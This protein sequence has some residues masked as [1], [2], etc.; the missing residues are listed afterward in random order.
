MGQRFS[1]GAKQQVAF[2]HR[3]EVLAVDPNEVDAAIVVI[4]RLFFRQYPRHCTARIVQF[5]MLNLNVVLCLHL[6]RHPVD[7]AIGAR[8][9]APGIP[10]NGLVFSLCHHTLPITRV[11]VG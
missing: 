4:A 5:Y 3:R 6:L 11:G 10:V 7:V 2:A 8:I 9:T 1:E